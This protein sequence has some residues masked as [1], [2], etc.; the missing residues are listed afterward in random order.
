MPAPPALPAEEFGG[1][2][3][4]IEGGADMGPEAT[5]SQDDGRPPDPAVPFRERGGGVRGRWDGE[6]GWENEGGGGP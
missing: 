4:T 2:R 3:G 6:G 5:G 1:M